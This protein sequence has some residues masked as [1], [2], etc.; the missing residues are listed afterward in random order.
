M[1]SGGRM[2]I[3]LE[4]RMGMREVVQSAGTWLTLKATEQQWRNLDDDD[5]PLPALPWHLPS[6]LISSGSSSS[7]PLVV[8][9]HY[10]IIII[11]FAAFSLCR[12]RM[13]KFMD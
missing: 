13:I 11:P 7:S 5:V 2:R 12:Q 1:L 6:L 9:L 8:E 4:S 3:E 10:T